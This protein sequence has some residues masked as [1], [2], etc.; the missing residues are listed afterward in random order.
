MKKVMGVVRKIFFLLRRDIWLALT[1]VVNSKTFLEGNNRIF[2][3]ANIS[4]STI[5][6]G[7]YI[8]V[9]SFLPK[10]KIGRF[11]T[12]GPMV[13]LVRGNHPSH[14]FV[15][16]HPAFYSTRKQAGFTFVEENKFKEF[17]GSSFSIEIGNDVWIGANVLILEGIKIGDGA[18]I[19][20]G[21][22]VSKD[23]LPY[24]INVGNPIKSIGE[25]FSSSDIV[26]LLK[27]QWW[28][29]EIEWIK[30][31]A[32]RFEDIEKFKKILN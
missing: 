31:N 5:G 16:I 7:T 32:D 1:S 9:D 30:D 14:K 25:R 27:F 28:N 21:A 6:F 24:S 12:I 23:I 15:S 3:G 18:I 26:K 13:R 2:P 8:G 4:N 10:S 20:S 11:T 29:K 17:S 19:G 22:V